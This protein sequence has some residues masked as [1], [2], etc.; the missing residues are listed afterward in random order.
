MQFQTSSTAAAALYCLASNPDKQEI[1]RQEIMKILPSKDVK[2]NER[3]LENI[4]YMRAVIKEAL[5][6]FPIFNGNARALDRDIVLQGY[7]I[8]KGV[9]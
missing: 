4:P 2:M 7:Q 6:M 8:P 9:S 3:S 5:R 1:L